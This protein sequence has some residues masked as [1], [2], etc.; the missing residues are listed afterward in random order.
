M[1][2]KKGHINNRQNILGREIRARCSPHGFLSL[3]MTDTRAPQNYGVSQNTINIIS[4]IQLIS[5]I[6]H[7]YSTAA[8]SSLP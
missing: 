6:W 2:E 7:S 5:E 3:L 4:L 8:D 1:G